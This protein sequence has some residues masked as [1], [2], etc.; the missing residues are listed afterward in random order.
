MRVI[1]CDTD[2]SETT[3]SKLSQHYPD[4]ELKLVRVYVNYILM[5]QTQSQSCGVFDITKFLGC[6]TTALERNLYHY[7]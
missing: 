2:L 7:S 1:T 4:A 5:N 3:R 6:D